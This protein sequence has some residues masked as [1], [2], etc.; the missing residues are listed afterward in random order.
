M[1]SKGLAIEINFSLRFRDST[2]TSEPVS[3]QKLLIIEYCLIAKYRCHNIHSFERQ[4]H[5]MQYLAF[6][7]KD[8][9]VGGNSPLQKSLAQ[10]SFAPCITGKIPSVFGLPKVLSSKQESNSCSPCSLP[11]L[12]GNQ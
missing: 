3:C 12:V 4:S 10:D 7:P 11:E 1:K 6:I 2:V 5:N 9:D 8:G